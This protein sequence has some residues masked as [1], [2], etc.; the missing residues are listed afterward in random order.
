MLEG[1]DDRWRDA[2]KRRQAFYTDLQPGKYRF[3]VIACNGDGVW[4]QTGASVDF[5][6][7]P[8][9]YQ[10]AWFK[11]A[12][13]GFVLLALWSA[14]QL[15]VRRLHRQFEI[16]VEARVSERTR[17]AR[18]LHD[19][20]L[21]S[22]QGSL[23]YFQSASNL[24]PNR[25]NEAKEKLDKAID[26]ASDAISEARDAV[27]GLRSPALAISDL[28]IALRALGES[29][30]GD[31]T[32]ISPSLD[33]VMEGEP[34]NLNPVVRDE[35][36]RIAAEAL[37]NA[38]RHARASRIEVEI[39]YDIKQLRVRIRDDGKGIDRGTLGH[40]ERTGHYGLHGMRERANLMGGNLEVWSDVHSGTEI[41]VTIPGSIAY[42]RDSR[43][44][45]L[46]G[47]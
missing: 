45:A 12:V 4:N 18:D 29:L 1:H 15:R 47:T 2:G 37:R 23:L 33:V 7:L 20:L 38:F 14:Y 5:S 10:T 13:A 26:E 22:F 6:V 3:R 43:K 41:E 44:A 24:L 39:R 17:I 9:Y 28:G 16:G 21:Q 32:A 27:A 35:V 46:R 8:A 25:P 34:R 19:T 11:L 36:F 40:G 30:G 31:P 42:Q